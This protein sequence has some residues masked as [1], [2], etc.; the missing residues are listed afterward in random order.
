MQRAFRFF[1]YFMDNELRQH[2]KRVHLAKFA[3]NVL[4][5]RFNITVTA[6]FSGIVSARTDCVRP[7]REQRIIEVLRAEKYFVR[8]PC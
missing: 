1:I 6:L 7:T 3:H 8:L 5:R 2:G 4:K